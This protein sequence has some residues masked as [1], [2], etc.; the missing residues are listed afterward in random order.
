MSDN[1]QKRII[2]I[3]QE[4]KNIPSID[5]DEGLIEN[6]VL[7]SFDVINLIT[8]LERDFHITIPGELILPENIGYVRD[9][10]KLVRTQQSQK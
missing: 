1:I 8:A 6:G 9:I 10:V 5:P 2:S 4:I 7:D 3:I